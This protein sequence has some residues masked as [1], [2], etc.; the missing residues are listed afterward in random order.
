ME[1]TES[2]GFVYNWVLGAGSEGLF[3]SLPPILFLYS[4]FKSEKG[5]MESEIVINPSTKLPF[6]NFLL[7]SEKYGKYALYLNKSLYG[8]LLGKSAFLP[9]ECAHFEPISR[10]DLYEGES[11]ILQAL[12]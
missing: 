12:W 2:R 7:I 6:I 10:A 11:T 3:F 5:G 8:F 9:Q 1:E 4:Y